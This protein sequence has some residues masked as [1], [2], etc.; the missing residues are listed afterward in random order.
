MLF[1]KKGWQCGPKGRKLLSL[2]L[3]IALILVGLSGYSTAA[4]QDIFS[5]TEE[6]RI[7]AHMADLPL[8]Q[9]LAELSW[10]VPLEIRGS[11]AKE[12]RLTLDFSRLTLGG[13]LREMM[14]GYNYVLITPKEQEKP[15]LV[16]L[17]KAESDKGI[18]LASF[19]RAAA[20]F[21][22]EDSS[23]PV[24]SGRCVDLNPGAAV[25]RDAPSLSR[26]GKR[27]AGRSDRGA[28]KTRLKWGRVSGRGVESRLRAAVQPGCVG[29]P[30]LQGQ[31][32]VRPEVAHNARVPHPPD[33]RST[34]L[35]RLYPP[36]AFTISFG[37]D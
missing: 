32:S 30:R 16:V 36:G 7:T 14:A 10:R 2:P 35:A 27:E 29:R 6:G 22:R 34:I 18:A 12:E 8:E 11:V 25:S 19:I 26:I 23:V 28:S 31:R 24:F 9:A 13:A 15:I 3:V 20:T 4:A 33:L 21:V 5:V 1:S 37:I 17:G